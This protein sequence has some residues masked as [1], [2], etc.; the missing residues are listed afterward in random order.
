MKTIPTGFPLRMA[1]SS[2]LSTPVACSKSVG[3][4]PSLKKKK[5]SH[6]ENKEI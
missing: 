1:S 3:I 4:V 6:C 5:K 2:F